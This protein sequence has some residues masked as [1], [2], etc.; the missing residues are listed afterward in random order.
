MNTFRVKHVGRLLSL[1]ML[2]TC[3]GATVTSAQTQSVAR[4]WNEA[5]LHAIRIDFPHPPVHARNLFH[6]SVAMWDAWAAYDPVAVG[7]THNE[8]AVAADTDAARQE[9]VSYAAYSVLKTRYALSVASSNTLPTLDTLLSSLG[10]DTN[11]TSTV[12]STPAAVGNRAAQAIL[13]FSFNDGSLEGSNY[14][15]SSYTAVNAPL[16]ID[17]PGIT[18]ND[19]NRWQPLA[20]DTRVTQN[21][22]IAEKI[23]TFLGSQ[24]YQVRPFALRRDAPSDAYLDPGMPPQIGGSG[25]EAF[26]SNNVAVLRFSSFLDPDATLTI[27]SSP[28][29]PGK[30]NNLGTHSGT[31]H[32]TNPKT[33]LPYTTNIVNLADF[34]RAAA[35][36]W[37][38]GPDS[39]TPPGHWNTLA[40]EAFEHPDFTRR[41]EGAG[42]ALDPLQWDV[43][44]YFAINAALHDAATAAWTAKRIYDY[45]RPICS[46][47]WLA[48]QGQ[49]SD[50]GLPN[51]HTNGI[52]LVTNLIELITVDS[53]QAGERHAH[54]AGQ[55]GQIAVHTWPG[56]PTDPSTEYS[57]RAWIL[58]DRWL[59]Y[60]RAT[61]VSPAFAGYVSGHSTFSRAAA[62]VLTAITGDAYF[63]G[64]LASHITPANSL[65]FELGPSTDVDLQWATYYDA[66]NE[67]GISRLYGGI[68]VAVD[69]LPGRIMGSQLGIDAYDLA[70][71]YF[72]GSITNEP[73]ECAISQTGGT[74]TVSW[75]QL[76]GMS[77]NLEISTDLTA[78]PA[79][80]FTPITDYQQAI[81]QQGHFSTNINADSVF[82]KINR[83]P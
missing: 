49:S 38:D 11:M 71:K 51:F 65:A 33:G 69:D 13:D 12:G 28:A 66:A 10:Y 53:T 19:P 78:D 52:P 35:E 48:S 73:L 47:R 67:A 6:L 54:L 58:A 31:G 9:A 76:Y 3:L 77:Y 34:G 72:D 64:G 14:D 55:I 4:I 29:G 61:F 27:D 36:F 82:Y 5:C 62:E 26:Q 45:V 39:E 44:T 25:H 17:Q 2:L 16:I 15:D 7:Y 8:A 23:Q 24:W 59:P 1:V 30:N 57:G 22:I 40:N 41:F 56:E 74:F 43:K 80:G 21:G 60:Q 32:T 50:P 68:H 75:E 70:R 37:A 18:M 83:T 79:G 46:I 81:E 20:F 63:P 42:P